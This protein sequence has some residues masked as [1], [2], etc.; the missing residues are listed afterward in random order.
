MLSCR[1]MRE[2]VQHL[3]LFIAQD[4]LDGAI[5][6]RL[7]P[8]SR[9]QHMSELGIFAGRQRLEDSPLLEQLPLYRL[10]AGKDLLARIEV[11]RAYALARRTQL[12]K[13]QLE[14][15]LSD[16]MLDDEQH[17]V[18]VSLAAERM[19]GVQQAIEMEIA[20]IGHPPL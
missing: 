5:L 1:V 18:V 15:Q 16:L 9:P 20:R 13:D 7:K 17:L 8:R 10:H 19:L 3:H 2:K 11:V 12:I 4:E 14:P 6:V